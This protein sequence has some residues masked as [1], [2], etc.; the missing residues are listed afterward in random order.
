MFL[1]TVLAACAA[2]AIISFDANAAGCTGSSRQRI[3]CLEKKLDATSAKLDA[4]VSKIEAFERRLGTVA[5]V[6]DSAKATAEDALKKVNGI[7]PPDLNNVRIR[8]SGHGN[9]CIYVEDG[10][11]TVRVATTKPATCEAG[12][13]QQFDLLLK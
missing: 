2:L 7:K 12:T 4:A 11:G 9:S 13:Q 10:T 6:A 8:W 3:D 1:R 5:T